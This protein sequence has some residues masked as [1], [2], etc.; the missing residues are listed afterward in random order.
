MR[1]SSAAPKVALE[2]IGH[3]SQRG[4]DTKEHCAQKRVSPQNCRRT[5]CGFPRTTVLLYH[6]HW[7]GPWTARLRLSPSTTQQRAT[8]ILILLAIILHPLAL[9]TFLDLLLIHQLFLITVG[10]LKVIINCCF[11][12]CCLAIIIINSFNC[13]FGQAEAQMFICNH[14][15]LL[16]WSSCS[17]NV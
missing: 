16:F 11:G 7:Q 14:R 1:Q 9:V 6:V 3:L 15:Q 10:T 13:C 17:R 4:T 12:F 2:D 5:W 8:L